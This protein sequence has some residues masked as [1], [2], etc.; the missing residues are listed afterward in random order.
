MLRVTFV[1]ALLVAYL[2]SSAGATSLQAKANEIRAAMEAR[3]FDRAERLVRELR[4]SDP[5]AFTSNS[6]DYLLARL[7]QRRGARAEAISL[8]L[9]ALNRD[10]VLSPYALWHLGEVARSTGDLALERQYLTRLIARYPSSAVVTEA[11]ERM[12]DSLIDSKEHESAIAL[13]RPI[14]SGSGTVGRKAMLKLGEAYSA[15]GNHTAARSQFERLVA[16]SRD[17]YALGAAAA[18][19]ELDRR[20]GV[21][22]DEFETLRRARIYLSNR[23]WSQAREHLLRLVSEFPQSPNRAEAIYQTGFTFYREDRYDEAIKWFEQAYVEF[24]SK[25]EGEQGYYYVATALQKARR[26]NEA[27]RR[28]KDFIDRY[29]SSDLVEG[30]YRNVV[31]CLRYAGSDSEALLW[32]RRIVADFTGKP[33]VVVGL[34]NEAKIELARGNYEAA[35]QLLER[36]QA[37][38]VYPKVISAPIR[39]EAAFLR[40]VAIEQAGRLAEAIRLFSVIPD[41][42]D[43]YFGHR[44][45]MRL[46]ALAATAEGKRIIHPLARSYKEQARAA[47][48]AGRYGEAKGA[49]SQALRLSSDLA[50]Q[51]ELIELLRS[52]YERLSAYRAVWDYRLVDAAR[53]VR[54]SAVESSNASPQTL[55]AELLFLGLCDE[56][57]V[58]LRRAG[59]AYGGNG[60]GNGQSAYSL[61]VYSNRGDQAQHAIR[62][63]EFALKSIPQDYRLELLPRDVAE[64]IYPAP[65]RET[66]NAYVS[67]RGIDPRL[68]LALVRQESRFDASAKSPEA[69]RG[70]LQ[71]ISETAIETAREEGLED[72]ELDD[73]Y[74]PQVAIRLAARHVAGLFKRFPRSTHAVAAAYNTG[75][76]N[77]E[78]WLFRAR[79]DDVDRFVAEIAIPETKDYVA[80]V[81][82][83]Y[84]AYQRL[85]TR[86]LKPAR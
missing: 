26:Y 48:R 46:Q 57:A 73:V 68:V 67:P 11:R 41:E 21:R 20:A 42:R 22:P 35:A 19:D 23:H 9:A 81:M 13:L 78:R 80:K 71:F 33:L 79:S 59:V 34:F 85:Y 17:D 76:A 3:E 50:E 5:V 82:N 45:T 4:A 47:F 2:A 7:A 62:Y 14:A 49:A 24:E 28:Y 51:R 64:L 44:A 55:A 29:P 18:L 77:V 53:A 43:N 54:E 66:F 12:I 36:L 86:D 38:P 61:A 58:E 83:N 30:A 8:Y 84:R 10:S 25:K 1:S 75:A 65:Y 74:E 16:G 69:A 15:H 6:Y 56:G 37:Y 32:S 40:A 31:D 52:S 27:A 39:G 63:A 60:R 72:F 70:L